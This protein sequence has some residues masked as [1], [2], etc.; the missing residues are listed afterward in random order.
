[1]EGQPTHTSFGDV[2]LGLDPRI[3]PSVAHRRPAVRRR[4]AYLHP[5][6]ALTP[7]P[8]V[9][10]EDDG[11]EA[12]TRAAAQPLRL[13]GFADEPPPHDV[14]RRTPFL[15]TEWRGGLPQAVEEQSTHHA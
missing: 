1:V 7:D 5:I 10:P 3:E 14:G 9:K 12:A 2:I 11:V 15:P 4:S 13:A 6:D 8:R